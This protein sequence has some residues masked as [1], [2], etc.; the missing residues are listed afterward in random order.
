[1]EENRT[2]KL[3]WR[4]VSRATTFTSRVFNVDDCI[5]ETPDGARQ[6]HY[7]SIT[8]PD[9]AIVV[10]VITTPEGERFVM[11]RQWRHGI[12]RMSC[13]F[14]GGVV[15]PGESPETGAA[16]E[17]A[18]ETGYHAGRI[19]HLAD[20]SVNAPLMSQVAHI[21]AALDLSGPHDRHLDKDEFVQVV[22]REP[23]EIVDQFGTGEYTHALMLSALR[24]YERYKSEKN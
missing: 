24:L 23:Q 4:P 22:L 6:G 15:D 14:P 17:L 13:E 20:I 19:V 3:E 10:P 8:A 16:R 9:C 7:Y 11:V 21:Y 1:M 12:Q 18:E 2:E 5:N